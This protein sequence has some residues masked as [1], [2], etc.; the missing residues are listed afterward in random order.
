MTTSW[1]EK[2]GTKTYLDCGDNHLNLH[3]F[4]Q[5]GKRDSL[6]FESVSNV[7]NQSRFQHRGAWDPD[8]SFINRRSMALCPFFNTNASTYLGVILLA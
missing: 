4:F 2:A 8:F 1:K 6:E 7:M 3:L 5:L